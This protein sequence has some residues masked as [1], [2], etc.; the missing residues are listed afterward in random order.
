MPCMT[1]EPFTSAVVVANLALSRRVPRRHQES[2]LFNSGEGHSV[3]SQGRRDLHART[4]KGTLG[5]VV[6][7]SSRGA[8]PQEAPRIDSRDQP[9]SA[10]ER[11]SSYTATRRQGRKRISLA[12]L[13]DSCGDR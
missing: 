3:G 1:L 11:R 9:P 6:S 13:H 7:P 4:E 2:T 12:T 5:R 10:R 8:G